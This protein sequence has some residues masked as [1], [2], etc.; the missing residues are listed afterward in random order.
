MARRAEELFSVLEFVEQA[1][2]PSL[3]WLKGD[4]KT[5]SPVGENGVA[6]R[7]RNQSGDLAAA[8]DV[9]RFNLEDDGEVARMDR[10]GRAHWASPSAD[11]S[12]AACTKIWK[13][14]ITA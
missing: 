3:H 2:V 9:A 5:E 4:L 14:P 8:H 6:W 13:S 12:A 7:V 11:Q 1:S 10:F